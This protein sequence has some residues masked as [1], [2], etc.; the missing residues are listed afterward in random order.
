MVQHHHH[1][2]C[3]LWTNRLKKIC[4]CYTCNQHTWACALMLDSREQLCDKNWTSEKFGVQGFKKSKKVFQQ[5]MKILI[6]SKKYRERRKNTWK[7]VCTV[8]KLFRCSFKLTIFFYKNSFSENLRE[9][10]IW[11]KSSN[12]SGICAV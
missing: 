5:V 3:H 10:K 9:I 12:W 7:I 11:K 2:L 1:P 8:A 6:K 4:C